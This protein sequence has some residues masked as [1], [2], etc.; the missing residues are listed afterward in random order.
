MTVASRIGTVVNAFRA[1]YR[2]SGLPDEPVWT[3]W[4]FKS[5]RQD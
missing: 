5:A 3:S 4:I 1:F 2:A